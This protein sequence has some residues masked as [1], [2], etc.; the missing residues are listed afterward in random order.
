MLDGIRRNE[1]DENREEA[2]SG[3]L[4]YFI[5]TR[6][7]NNAFV[8]IK[9]TRTE[10]IKPMQIM[11]TTITRTKTSRIR[12]IKQKKTHEKSS[13]IAENLDSITAKIR[14]D[15]QDVISKKKI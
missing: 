11:K 4:F 14:E 1:N 15:F 3:I 5:S 9:L 6:Q 7:I 2:A 10:M 12:K 8:S 13:Q